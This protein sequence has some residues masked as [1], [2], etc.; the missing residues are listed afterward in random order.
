MGHKVNLFTHS[1]TDSAHVGVGESALARADDHSC[2][3]LLTF[4]PGADPGVDE[5]CASSGTVLATR[6]CVSPTAPSPLLPVASSR[7]TYTGSLRS[8]LC[9][10]LDLTFVTDIKEDKALLT[11]AQTTNGRV[12][13]SPLQSDPYHHWFAQV[14]V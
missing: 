10:S 12:S 9:P 14:Q 3:L 2:M 5:G 1:V 6:I 11:E 8:A 13:G 7:A 4:A